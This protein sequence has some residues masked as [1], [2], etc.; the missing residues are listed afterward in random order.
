MT[1]LRDIFIFWV[2]VAND[3]PPMRWRWS[4]VVVSF[5]VSFF[6]VVRLFKRTVLMRS[7]F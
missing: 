7:V 4:C 5:H 6:V 3:T 2:G 1:I